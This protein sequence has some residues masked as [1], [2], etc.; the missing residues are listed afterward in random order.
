MSE[1]AA[2]DLD[3]VQP[4]TQTQPILKTLLDMLN[5]YSIRLCRILPIPK[6]LFTVRPMIRNVDTYNGRQISLIK[7]R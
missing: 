5:E 1:S 2:A 6:S 3:D 7:P 4:K